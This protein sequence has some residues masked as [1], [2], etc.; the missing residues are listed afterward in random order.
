MNASKNNAT[1]CPTIS[2]EQFPSVDRPVQN[3]HVPLFGFAASKAT[4]ANH[5]RLEQE[6]KSVKRVTI[7]I[8]LMLQKGES[9]DEVEIIGGKSPFENF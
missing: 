1:T 5:C 6:A 7:N 4:N 3:D 2:V 8:G 9:A